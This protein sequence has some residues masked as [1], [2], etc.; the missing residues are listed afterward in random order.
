MSIATSNEELLKSGHAEPGRKTVKYT[1]R[2][3]ASQELSYTTFRD[4]NRQ[5][6]STIRT[7]LQKVHQDSDERRMAFTINRLKLS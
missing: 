2:E 5:N 1:D 3:R 4:A 6:P 7:A